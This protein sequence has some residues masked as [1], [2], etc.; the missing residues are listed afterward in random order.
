MVAILKYPL[1]VWL[2]NI[3]ISSI[4]LLNPEDMGSR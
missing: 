3:L 1:L 4:E 2:Y